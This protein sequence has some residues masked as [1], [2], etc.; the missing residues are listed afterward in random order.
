MVV[1]SVGWPPV[2]AESGGCRAG[3]AGG[4]TAASGRPRG[5]SGAGAQLPS[6][7]SKVF[8]VGGWSEIPE[9]RPVCEQNPLLEDGLEQGPAPITASKS[10]HCWE[11]GLKVQRLDLFVGKFIFVEAK[12]SQRRVFGTCFVLGCFFKIF[13]NFLKYY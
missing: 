4:A 13:L 8:P 12:F 3:A 10:F 5:G 7:P 6:P 11:D 9:I 1:V 2:A